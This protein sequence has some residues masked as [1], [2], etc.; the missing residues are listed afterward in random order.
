MIELLVVVAIIAILA[1]LLLPALSKSR[2][3]AR[4]IA[5]AN[6]LY[7]IGLSEVL[8]AGDEDAWVASSQFP[9]APSQSTMYKDWTW[10]GPFNQG[11]SGYL[12]SY[13]PEDPRMR[14]CPTAEFAQGTDV[15]GSSIHV[16]GVGTYAGFTDWRFMLRKIHNSYII[17]PG[18]D[19]AFG[20]DEKDLIPIYMDPVVQVQPGFVTPGGTWDQTGMNMHGNG[21]SLPILMSDGHVLQYP[22]SQYNYIWTPWVPI[23]EI[24]DMM[25]FQ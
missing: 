22:R 11:A 12:D 21:G 13:L 19:A 20:W 15:F 25:D 7:Q 8:Y 17:S 9:G 24:S 18:F 5:C 16:V 3:A 10:M 6:N 4:E 23:S 2:E 14:I 1:S